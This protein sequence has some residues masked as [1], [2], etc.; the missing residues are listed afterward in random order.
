MFPTLKANYANY[1]DM[2]Q[3]GDFLFSRH[4]IISI[5]ITNF[6]MFPSPFSKFM[7]ELYHKTNSLSRVLAKFLRN[8]V[9][10]AVI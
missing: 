4:I 2:I 1:S 7:F 3:D 6:A 10:V 5:I 9:N 8:L